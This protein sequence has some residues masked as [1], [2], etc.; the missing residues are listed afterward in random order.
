MATSSRRKRTLH[1]ATFNGHLEVV[2]LLLEAGT[3]KDA[4]DSKEKT[5]LN[6]AAERGHQQVVLEAES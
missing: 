4:T 2:W 5:A 6:L 3:N 1:L